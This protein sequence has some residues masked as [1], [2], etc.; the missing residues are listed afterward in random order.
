MATA[1]RGLMPAGY[2]DDSDSS[3]YY[4][5]GDHGGVPDSIG[6][7]GEGGEQ[8]NQGDTKTEAGD[9]RRNAYGQDADGIMR[10]LHGRHG[11]GDVD[12]APAERFAD[13]ISSGDCRQAKKCLEENPKLLE[14]ELS[15]FMGGKPIAVACRD[16]RPDLVRLLLSLGASLGRDADGNTPFLALCSSNKIVGDEDDE[17]LISCALAFFE[18][19]PGDLDVNHRQSQQLSA[20]MLA[21]KEGRER[22]CGLLV[23]K[24]AH[25]DARDSQGWTPLCFA[26]DMGHGAVVR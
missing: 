16:S 18:L 2:S 7:A 23:D 1:S 13:A 12:M 21:A 9:W 14:K 5:E 8:A 3:D 4:G 15:G 20:L 24:G 17:D 6:G 25:K 19:R 22:L 26:A 10:T 11:A